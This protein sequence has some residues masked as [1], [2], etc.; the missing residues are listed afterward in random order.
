MGMTGSHHERRAGGGLLH[1]FFG[2]GKSLKKSWI[3][4]TGAPAGGGSSGA[5]A[6]LGAPEWRGDGATR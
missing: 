3:P 1:L 5:V 6:V 4:Y 2:R